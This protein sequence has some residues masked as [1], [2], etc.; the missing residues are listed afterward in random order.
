[1]GRRAALSICAAAIASACDAPRSE[2]AVTLRAVS[3][4]IDETDAPRLFDLVRTDER[5][6]KRTIATRVREAVE[7]GSDLLV[8]SFDRVLYRLREGKKIPIADR[9]SG[10][11]AILE[12]GSIVVSRLGDLPGETDLWLYPRS[13]AP[14]AIAPAPGPDDLPK[15]L[16]GG[17]IEFVSGRSSIASRWVVDVRGGPPVQLTNVGLVAGRDRAWEVVQ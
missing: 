6:G 15:A 17:R 11:P 10:A 2:V 7:D 3:A 9:V 14:R 13:G 16:P 8:V 4:P 5:G 1:M 12:D